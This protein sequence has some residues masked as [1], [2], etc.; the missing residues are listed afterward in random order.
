MSMCKSVSVC[1]SVCLCVRVCAQLIKAMIVP[2]VEP[3]GARFANDTGPAEP[4]G[5]APPQ[6][7]SGGV[8]LCFSHPPPKF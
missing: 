8:K 5:H 3:L 1:K 7:L 6:N 2:S 4:G